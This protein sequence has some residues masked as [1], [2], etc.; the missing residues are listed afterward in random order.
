[1][2]NQYHGPRGHYDLALDGR[3]PI[4]E[5]RP[6]PL[7]LFDEPT[8]RQALAPAPLPM[9]GPGIAEPGQDQDVG[10]GDPNAGSVRGM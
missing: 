6:L 9:A 7:G 10:L 1:M 2:G 5:A 8:G 3:D 4:G